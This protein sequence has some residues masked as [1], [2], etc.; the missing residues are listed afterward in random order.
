M[1]GKLLP[2]GDTGVYTPMSSWGKGV[3]TCTTPLKLIML[4]LPMGIITVCG[5]GA[6]KDDNS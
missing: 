1:T 5:F 4:L 6:I 2:Y 3:I